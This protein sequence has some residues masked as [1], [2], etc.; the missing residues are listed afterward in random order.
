V[1][2]LYAGTSGWAY[3][4]WRPRFYP[5]NLGPDKFLSYYASRLNAVEVN[6]TF[7]RLLTENL[8]AK[9]VAATPRDFQF[10]VKAHQA[11]THFRRLQNT[12]EP[13][14][15][16]IAGLQPLIEARKLGP[17][18]FQLPPN[19]KLDLPRLEKFLDD[20][21]TRLR[22]VF[23]FRH[24]SW[25]CEEVYAMLREAGSALCAAESGAAKAPA[26]RTARFSYLRLR[27]EKYPPVDRRRLARKSSNSSSVATYSCFS[28]TKIR[29]KARCGLKS[30]CGGDKRSRQLPFFGVEDCEEGCSQPPPSAL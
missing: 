12:A 6:Y 10:A 4:N 21:P 11:I 7:R 16:F 14:S 19:F 2:K 23:E 18:L 5:Q 30:C 13:M 15:K 8:T 22:T 1:G 20:L 17:V 27:K 24:P 26:I 9:W 29:Q 25:F 3:P 28:N